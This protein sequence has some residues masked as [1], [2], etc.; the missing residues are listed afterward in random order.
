MARATKAEILRQISTAR[1][2][3]ADE[4]RAGRRAVSAHYD[5]KAERVMLELSSGF[6]FGF[7]VRAIPALARATPKM[8]ALVQVSPGGG[9]LHWDGLDVDLSVPG[10][11]LASV[12][13]PARLR[14]LARLAGSART[15]AKAAAARANGAK[16][17][18]PAKTVRA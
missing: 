15:P 3:E 10:L 17:G 14:E 13:R 16:G 5:A 9:A 7:P 1:E 11:L 4:R 2:H 6:V 8:L 18:R 12:E